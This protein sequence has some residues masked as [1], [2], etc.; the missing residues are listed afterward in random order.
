MELSV[1]FQEICSGP[2]RHRHEAGQFQE[3]AREVGDLSPPRDLCPSDCCLRGLS[4][5][6]ATTLGAGTERGEKI[7]T[8]NSMR[9]AELKPP[10]LLSEGWAVH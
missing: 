8:D 1:T 3:H 10:V 7:L 6:G 4:H 2:P 9:I 5:K